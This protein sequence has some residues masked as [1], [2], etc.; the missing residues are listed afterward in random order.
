MCEIDYKLASI[1]AGKKRGAL[2]IIQEETA[3]NIY[4]P[5]PLQGLVGPDISLSPGTTGSSRS[6]SVIWITGEF[7][8]VQRAR[9]MLYQVSATK[10]RLLYTKVYVHPLTT[11]RARLS[12]LETLLFYHAS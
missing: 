3:T 5:S 7:F 8:G 10:V 9:D 4:L 1:I 12:F 2:Q 11:C 6:S